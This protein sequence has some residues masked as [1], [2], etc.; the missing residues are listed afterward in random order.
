M[1]SRFRSIFLAAAGGFL[2]MAAM[3][4]WSQAPQNDAPQVVQPNVERRE[5]NVGA[6]DTEDFELTGFIGIMSVED[7]ESSFVYGARLAYHINEALFAEATY[8]R[9]DVG[10]SSSEKLVGS[11]YFDDRTL[12]YYDLSLG[13]NVLP[14]ES[15]FGQR[16][17]YNSSFYVIGGLGT[18]DFAGD[19]NFT[20]NFGFGFKVLPTD[21]LAVRIEARDYLFDTDINADNKTLNNLQLTLNAS[22]FF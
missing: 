20:V 7:F 14:G 2:T 15:F 19:S 16:R 3:P 1:E 11:E 12:S 4:G 21:Y 22:W 10:E 6:I 13:W 5:L 18:T 9:T 17:A 8:G